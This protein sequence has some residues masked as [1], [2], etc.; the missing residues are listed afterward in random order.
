MSRDEAKARVKERGGKVASQTSKNVTHVVVG[1]NPGS[2][3]KRARDLGLKI[4]SEQDFV[5]L[6]A[7]KVVQEKKKQLSIF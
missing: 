2:K 1:T 5:K 3:L 7:G 4:V 6:L